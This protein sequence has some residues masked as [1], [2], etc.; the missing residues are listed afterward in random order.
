M[1]ASFFSPDFLGGWVGGPLSL[2]YGVFTIWM[3]IDAVRRKEYLWVVLIMAG[4][5]IWYFFYVYRSGPSAEGFELPGAAKRQRIKELQAKIHHLDNAVHHYQL[6]D[7]FFSQGKFT[8]AERCYRAA[9]ERDPR[10]IDARG[11]LGQCLMRLKRPSEARPLLEGVR[12]EDP[13]HDYGYSLMA[14]AE[15][16]TAL[17]ELDAARKT[18]LQVTEHHSYP[19]AKVQLAEL[20]LAENQPEFARTEL[21]EVLADDAHAPPFQRRRDRYWIRRA[22]SLVGRTAAAG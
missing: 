3:L 4:L 17:G 15:C 5:G 20:Y 14:L 13:K 8:L 2:A 6:G 12:A 21:T 10:D 9:L 16:L 7:I 1:V 11:H 18:W 22:R 19:R